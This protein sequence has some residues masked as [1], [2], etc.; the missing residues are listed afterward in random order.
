MATR[1]ATAHQFDTAEQQY[2]ADQM[3]MWIFLVTE[4]LFFGAIFCAYAIYRARYPEGWAL[5]SQLNNSSLAA[6]M[7]V[8]LILSSLTMAFSVRS[9]QLGNRKALILNLGLTMLLGLAFLV[10]KAY[11]YHEHWVE[12]LVPGLRFTGYHGPSSGPV[13]LF[14]C[15]YF[16]MTAVHALHMVIGIGVLAVLMAMAS[17]GRFH[18]SYFAPVEVSGLYWHFV[19]IVWIFLFPLL[20]LV[21]VHK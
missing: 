2:E 11:E 10:M 4:L 16:I 13:E 20:Y 9:A 17:R 5:G 1:D 12:G 3:G 21:D 7:T 15:F 6:A 14:V 18:A 8:V 19:D